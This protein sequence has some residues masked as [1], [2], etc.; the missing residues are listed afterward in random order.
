MVVPLVTVAVVVGSVPVGVG[1]VLVAVLVG[2]L[3]GVLVAAGVGVAAGVIVAATLSASPLELLT[4]T[5]YWAVVC[6]FR[7]VNVLLVAPFTGWLVS[8]AAPRYHW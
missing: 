3:V 6:R 7:T 5:Q 2:E 1:T 4:R 8:P